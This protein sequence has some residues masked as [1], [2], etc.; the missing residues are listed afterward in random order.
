MPSGKGPNAKNVRRF[1]ANNGHFPHGFTLDI[2]LRRSF[3]PWGFFVRIL[4]P[5][6]TLQELNEGLGVRKRV[7]AL[8]LCSWS[9]SVIHKGSAVVLSKSQV[10]SFRTKEPFMA[11]K[12]KTISLPQDQAVSNCHSSAVPQNVLDIIQGTLLP[13]HVKW[14]RVRTAI[15][16]PDD[17]SVLKGDSPDNDRFMSTEE[18]C[19]FI[20]TSRTSIFRL[21]KAGKLRAYKLGRRN[22]FSLSEVIAALKNEEAAND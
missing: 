11:D 16:S 1:I 4:I 21:I 15:L 22:L 3:P 8:E 18:L 17:R 19:E 12:Y 13:F 9:N 14:D 20:H 2:S 7:E 5:A 10:T 6:C